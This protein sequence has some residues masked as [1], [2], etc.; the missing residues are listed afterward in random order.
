MRKLHPFVIIAILL[1]SVGVSAVTTSEIDDLSYPQFLYVTAPSGL[2]VRKEADAK[3]KPVALLKK[4]SYFHFSGVAGGPVTIDSISSRWLKYSGPAGT[5]YVFGGFVSKEPPLLV[6]TREQISEIEKEN[7]AYVESLAREE[8]RRMEEAQKAGQFYQNC[9]ACEHLKIDW[10]RVEL[11]AGCDQNARE[12]IHQLVIEQIPGYD[13][14][15]INDATTR[16]AFLDAA[17]KVD[18]PYCGQLL[19]NSWQSQGPAQCNGPSFFD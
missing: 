12:R 9:D 8:Q 16:Q 11:R 5:G 2:Y 18:N 19:L 4:G 1:L 6:Y 17:E 10:R 7:R 15:G 14:S 13:K 3:S